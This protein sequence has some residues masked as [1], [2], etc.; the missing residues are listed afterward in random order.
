MKIY[1]VCGEDSG[2]LHA[3]NLAMQIK[4]NSDKIKMRGFGGNKM[5]DAGVEIAVHIK[6]LSFM[7]I[8]S[9]FLR[10]PSLIR[11]LNFCKKDIINY[12]PDAIILIDYPG[13]NLKIAKFASKHGIKVF[14]YIPPKVW[15]SRR[16]RIDVIRKYVDHLIVIFPF[17]VD[18]YKNHGIQA[19]YFGN[20]IIDEIRK[21]IDP[22]D[23]NTDKKVIALLPG[24]RDHE[25]RNNLPVMASITSN[26]PEYK[27]IVASTSG[28]YDLCSNLLLGTDLEVVKDKTY[29]VL[30]ESEAAVVTSGTSTLEAALIN[31]PQIVCYRT[32][33]VTFYLARLLINIKWI[34]LVNI[35]LNKSLVNELIQKEVTSSNLTLELENILS[36]EGRSKI[37][38]GYNH[39]SEIIGNDLVS[40]NLSSFILSKI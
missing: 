17:E 10:L 18:F 11:F 13:F 35:I 9:V 6:A 5:K 37:H 20:P 3:A 12:K 28:T 40:S 39:L 14:Y 4:K 26:F 24:S 31:V 8:S 32:D 34:S 16:G 21:G 36:K 29:S 15:A 30:K 38:L 7:G 27:F 2:D 22:I 33:V 1:F 23:L 25:I 19:H